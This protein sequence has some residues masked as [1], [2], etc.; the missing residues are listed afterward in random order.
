M[1]GTEAGSNQGDSRTIHQKD[2]TESV[3]QSFS[4]LRQA[5]TPEKTY[6]LSSDFHATKLPEKNSKY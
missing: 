1:S 4:S 5:K 2:T 6:C 3:Q